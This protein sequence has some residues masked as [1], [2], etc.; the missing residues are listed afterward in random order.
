MFVILTVLRCH[1]YIVSCLQG[2]KP[3]LL[4]LG[5]RAA[6]SIPRILPFGATDLEMRMGRA[7]GHRKRKDGTQPPDLCP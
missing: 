7:D 3:V 6:L 2:E 5:E 4:P 1:G